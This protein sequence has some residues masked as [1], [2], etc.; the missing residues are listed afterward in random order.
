M[1]T[2]EYAKKCYSLGGVKYSSKG[3]RVRLEKI[4]SLVGEN[5]KVLDIGCYDGTLGEILLKNGNKVFGIEAN[6][7]V[8]EIAEK[9]GLKV[10]IQDIESGIDF[11]DNFFDV[12]V[13]AEVIEHLVDT[14]FSLVK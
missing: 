7:E 14:D 11:E 2:Y 1:K 6:E 12:V 9:R 4:I 13:A 10:K 5:N 8:A 3:E